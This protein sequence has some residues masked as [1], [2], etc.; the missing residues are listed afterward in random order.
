MISLPAR[1][2]SCFRPVGRRGFALQRDLG[3]AGQFCVPCR[4]LC[5]LA[6][7]PA[8]S[9]CCSAGR[10]GTQLRGHAFWSACCRLLCG[11]GASLRLRPTVTSR[12][13]RHCR[14]W[15]RA[16]VNRSKAA[17][18]LE[19]AAGCCFQ[20]RL[21]AGQCYQQALEAPLQAKWQ[22]ATACFASRTAMQQ[23]AASRQHR[24]SCRWK[25]DRR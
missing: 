25:P 14:R 5:L 2:D 10:R 20:Q 1:R 16:L 9:A 11:S 24:A 7:R 23:R 17:C 18:G 12:R 22:A 19:A 15:A 21:I 8:D 6:A 13:W 3:R 4:R